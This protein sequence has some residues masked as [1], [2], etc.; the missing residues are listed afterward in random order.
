MT[1]NYLLPR[2]GSPW[3]ASFLTLRPRLSNLNFHI[4][5]KRCQYAEQIL[6]TKLE[7]IA[8]IQIRQLPT[9]HA[10]TSGSFGLCPILSV[11]LGP[12]LIYQAGPDFQDQRLTLKV[13]DGVENVFV[14]IAHRVICEHI[15]THCGAG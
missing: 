7:R 9:G 10:E 8:S 12:D 6:Q 13:R 14:F 15:Q 1:W 2:Y 4:T 3:W 5:S 11:N